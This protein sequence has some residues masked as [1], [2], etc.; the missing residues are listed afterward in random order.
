MIFKSILAP[1]DGSAP[2]NAA[3]A[4]AI[5]LAKQAGA[6]L[7]FCHVERVPRAS[8]DAGG[9][10]REEIREE[11]G[12]IAHEVLDA[13]NKLAADAGIQAQTL[14]LAEPV[15]EAIIEAAKDNAADIIIMGT[16]GRAGIVRA[17][18]GSK[19]ADV[20]A[21]SP[22]PVLVAPHVAA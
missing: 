4:L 14:R 17:V 21:R 5:S 20:I 12:R 1:V 7:V 11:E 2:S 15:A 19:T 16:H 9:F 22:I 18:L 6:K 3:A 10:A 8:H 13:A